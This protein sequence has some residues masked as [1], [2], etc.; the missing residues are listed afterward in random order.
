MLL[1]ILFLPLHPENTLSIVVIGLG[2]SKVAQQANELAA[3]HC[4]P[5]FNP[6]DASKSEELTPQNVPLTSTCAP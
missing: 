3:Q 1:F 5:T 6:L 2:S 4:Q